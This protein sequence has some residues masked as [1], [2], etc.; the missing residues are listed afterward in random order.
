ME[1]KDYI[2][3]NYVSN[4]CGAETGE[5]CNG[6][7]LCLECKEWCEVVEEGTKEKVMDKKEKDSIW[8]VVCPKCLCEPERRIN[9]NWYEIDNKPC[10]E[11]GVDVVPMLRKEWIKLRNKN[12]E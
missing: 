6:V 1:K 4:C 3:K 8:A 10:K 7:A 5:E 9:G 2:N 11:C 12:N